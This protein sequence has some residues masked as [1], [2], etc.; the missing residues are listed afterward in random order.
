MVAGQHLPNRG[1]Q[2]TRQQQCC[3][4]TRW[5]GRQMP[6]SQSQTFV[7]RLGWKE[8]AVSDRQNGR[9]T[10]AYSGA[11]CSLS[12][13]PRV[14]YYYLQHGGTSKE[15]RPFRWQI[16]TVTTRG[17]EASGLLPLSWARARRPSTAGWELSLVE[18]RLVRQAAIA[19]GPGRGF[20]SRT[21]MGSF[22]KCWH[23]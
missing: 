19:R 3:S 9:L 1:S 8:M 6:S 23:G 17:V 13:Q 21:K 11:A 18:R 12:H 15:R 22:R 14:I 7:R 10:W 2:K 16:W 4:L 5:L 20:S